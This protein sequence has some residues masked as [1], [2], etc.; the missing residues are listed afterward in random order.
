MWNSYPSALRRSSYIRQQRLWT[1]S[2]GQR[3][4]WI[5]LQREWATHLKLLITRNCL[6]KVF[7]WE[8]LKA[9]TL[10]NTSQP[11][12]LITQLLQSPVRPPLQ[13]N[14][15]QHRPR[16]SPS[17]VHSLQPR[18]LAPLYVIVRGMISVFLFSFISRFSDRQTSGRGGRR[19][20][21]IPKIFQKWT[22]LLRNTSHST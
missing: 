20:F 19:L 21:D 9:R 3:S 6:L 4:R 12:D 15:R 8:R 11:R 16:H 18:T 22:K 2:S 5:R 13:S 10:S 17:L 7:F 1:R 14:Q